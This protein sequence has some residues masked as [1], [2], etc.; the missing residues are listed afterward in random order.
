MY[1]SALALCGMQFIQCK[2]LRESDPRF[3]LMRERLGG[4]H[5]YSSSSSVMLVTR[6]GPNDCGTSTTDLTDCE[7][8]NRSFFPWSSTEFEGVENVVEP[9]GGGPLPEECCC[10]S[11]GRS[12]RCSTSVVPPRD[13]GEKC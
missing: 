7:R 10:A 11:E 9:D 5:A 1:Y 6:S 4:I 12:W 13:M 3:W 2:E 8:A